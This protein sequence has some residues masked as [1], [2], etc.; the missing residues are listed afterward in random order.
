MDKGGKAFILMRSMPSVFIKSASLASAAYISER[1]FF[2]LVV[3][4]LGVGTGLQQYFFGM[5]P[6]TEHGGDCQN[7]GHHRHRYTNL[8]LLGSL[9]LLCGLCEFLL[10]LCQVPASPCKSSLLP[11]PGV[12]SSSEERTK[13]PSSLSGSIIPPHLSSRHS[14]SNARRIACPPIL[15]AD[16]P[17]DV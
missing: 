15:N 9:S 8:F 1:L 2:A 10:V 6:V 3:V 14:S 13:L 5:R 7:D 4:P 12:L 11:S 16:V 17:L